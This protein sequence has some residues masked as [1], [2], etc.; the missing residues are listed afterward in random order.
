MARVCRTDGKILLLEHG[1]IIEHGTHRD[2]MLL[3]KKYTALYTMQARRYLE[4]EDL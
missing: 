3:G 1:E 4:N 2:L